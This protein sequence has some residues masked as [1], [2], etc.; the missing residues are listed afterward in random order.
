MLEIRVCL[1]VHD[2][3]GVSGHS[4]V[5]F[6]LPVLVWGRNDSVTLAKG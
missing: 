1:E 5:H 6:F 4:R 2:T 3:S